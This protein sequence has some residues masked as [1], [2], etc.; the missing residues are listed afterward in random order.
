MG[1]SEVGKARGLRAVAPADPFSKLVAYIGGPLLVAA[2]LGMFHLWR[3]V[4]ILEA[5]AAGLPNAT[6]VALL[7]Q[8]MRRLASDKARD[9]DQDRR[10][11]R[12][13]ET[14]SWNRGRINAIE[15]H[16]RLP[17]SSPPPSTDSP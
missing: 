6:E 17:I 7:Q 8:E 4:I 16:L 15:A 13:W 3:Q 11:R 9:D 5:R 2:V 14:S 12:Q 1:D 10:I